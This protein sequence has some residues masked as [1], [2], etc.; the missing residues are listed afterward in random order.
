[1]SS[2]SKGSTRSSDEMNI[3]R[4]A[5]YYY[6]HVMDLNTNVT[7]LVNGPKTYI[8]QDNEKVI[9]GPEKMITIPPRHYC[10]VE[11]PAIRDK[12]GNVVYD[13]YGQ[14]KLQHADLE[15]RFSQEPFP[16]YPGEVYRQVPKPLMV[17][18]ANAALRLKAIL[19]FEDE[20]SKTNRVAGDEWLF[21]GPGIY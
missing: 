7:R 4:I 9:F 1:M 20:T 17:V 15:I 2:H 18:A 10:I 8:R 14:A 12:D 16:L 5:P 19:D 13:N 6:I 21:E 3:F 11:S